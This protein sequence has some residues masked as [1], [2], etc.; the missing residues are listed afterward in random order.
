MRTIGVRALR[1]KLSEC[2]RLAAAGKE[3]YHISC[4]G[5]VLAL[6]CRNDRTLGPSPNGSS[7]ASESDVIRFSADK[8]ISRRIKESVRGRLQVL[9][10]MSIEELR[11]SFTDETGYPAPSTM[12]KHE[13]HL[14][15][16]RA[17]QFKL[18]I[19]EAGGVP[20]DIGLR[21]LEFW[22]ELLLRQNP[23]KIIER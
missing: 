8:A 2:I 11:E 7:N 3:E 19:K 14:A 15:C 12:T 1:A 6:L 16:G 10:T 22:Y 21:D 18:W 5:K 17:F 13:L 4:H 23:Q 9:Q 20:G